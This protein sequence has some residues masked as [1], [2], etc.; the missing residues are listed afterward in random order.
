MAAQQR[1]IVVGGGV[2][3]PAVALFLD[4]A[5]IAATVF[6][7]RE[8]GQPLGGGFGL[9]PNGMH[10]LAALGLAGD[11]VRRG[12]P[13]AEYRFRN[14]SGRVLAGY[15][16]RSVQRFGQPMVG[17]R[18]PVLQDL[19]SQA[20]RR[21]GIAVES[22][23]RLVGVEQ[24][25][26]GVVAR[27][28][29]GSAAAG[30]FLVGADGIHSAA[31]RSVLPEGPG[32]SYT[33]LVGVGAI[34]PRALV[35]AV[36]DR[37]V[38]GMTFTYGA[39]GFFGYCGGGEGQA[40]WWSNLPR[41]APYT[42]EELA[43]PADATQAELLAR[44]GAYHEPIPSLIRA[45]PDPFRLNVFD[46]PPLPAWHRGRVVLVGD[47][48]HA[49]SPNAGQGASLALEDAMYLARLLRDA[50]AG[51]GAAGYAAVFS[52]FEGDRKPRVERIVAEGRRRG[53]DKQLVG[54]FQERIRELLL[55][56][57][58][59]LFGPRGDDWLHR[60]RVD[61]NGAAPAPALAAA[62]R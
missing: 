7:A 52:R 57:F 34:V 27:F 22:G 26:R 6:E 19:L 43:A 40:M 59:N 9:A 36:S 37:D 25:A 29:D 60:Y 55:A 33:G 3:G 38:A 53:A 4:R 20:L 5:G 12:S 45:T 54:P 41:S 28:A 56:V 47:A 10:V 62:A 30:D 58:L 50:P 2:A 61:W 11:A 18:R 39:G 44:Y 51:A 1:A 13:V 21:R 32:A 23:R 48:A 24:D 35:P 49:V 14:A 46:V 31:R 42:R 8:A 16:L 15:P 17:L